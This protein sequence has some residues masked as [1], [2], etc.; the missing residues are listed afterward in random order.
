MRGL[1]VERERELRDYE[2]SEKKRRRKK[3]IL[4]GLGIKIIII[5]S[6][7]LQCTSIFRCAL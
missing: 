3:Y 4:I 5:F 1:K 6:F 7:L 2:S